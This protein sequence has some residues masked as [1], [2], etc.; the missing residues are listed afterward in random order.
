[1]VQMPSN[2]TISE[3]LAEYVAGM[4]LGDFPPEVVAKTKLCILDTIGCMLRGSRDEVAASLAAHALRYGPP[5]PCTI[6]GHS[7][8]VGPEHA[9]LANGTSAHVLEW[10]AGHRPSD[11]HLG[12]VVLPATLAMAQ[13]RGSSAAELLLSVALGYDVMGRIGEAVCLPRN[14][15]P[16]H[17]TG[18]T[19]VFG[20]AAAVGKLLGLNAR[21]LA[22]ALGVAGDGASGLREISPT[23]VDCFVLHAGKASQSGITAALLAAEGFQAPA[24]I[25]EGRYGFCNAMT[26]EA[27]PELICA[28][29]GQRFA[30]VE[31]GFKVHAC[32]GGLFTAIDAAL[33]LRTE[34]NLDPGSIQRIKVALPESVRDR[35]TCQQQPPPSVAAARWSISFT[36]AAALHDGEVTHRQLSQIKLADPGIA[37]LVEKVELVSDSE[38]EEIFYAQKRDDPFFFTPCAV[39]V[40]CGGRSYRRLERTPLGYDPL[41]RG[42]TQEQVVAKFR[43]VVDGILSE[44]QVDRMVDWV[45]RLDHG[46]KVGDLSG[47]LA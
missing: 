23:G 9:A 15:T 28:E 39:E 13:V 35:Y 5:G 27:R 22:N 24:T 42:L 32:H 31:C 16:F 41:K 3:R 43:S 1:M 8:S 12:G 38:V 25:I 21:Q 17:G 14:A 47:I 46:S 45:L 10:D 4:V 36:V 34:H 44:T 30:V 37:A 40:D 18:T 7:G 29:L 19:G 26:P 33:W 6:F 11:N 20:S 2:G